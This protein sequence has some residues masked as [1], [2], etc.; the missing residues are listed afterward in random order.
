MS[1]ED[2]HHLYMHWIICLNVLAIFAK[3][4]STSENRS[5][6]QKVNVEPLKKGADIKG[7]IV[8]FAF[9]CT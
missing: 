3:D 5:K 9:G 1:L 4:A 6:D 7:K 2:M 8:S